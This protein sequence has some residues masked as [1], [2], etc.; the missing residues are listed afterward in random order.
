MYGDIQ[1]FLNPS[2]WD[3]KPF[4]G[5]FLHSYIN[6]LIPTLNR[7]GA[8]Y[9][10]HTKQ[11]TQSDKGILFILSLNTC[12]SRLE[13]WLVNSKGSSCFHPSTSH[14]IEAK[15]PGKHSTEKLH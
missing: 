11:V 1:V 8:E 14:L 12:V 13:A 7:E 10:M 15:A 2:V 5:Y 9:T 6:F 4:K 3:F